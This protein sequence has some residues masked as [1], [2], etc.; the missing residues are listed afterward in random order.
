MREKVF[1]VLMHCG[2]YVDANLLEKGIYASPKPFIYSKEETIEGLI[3]QARE[4]QDFMG[5]WHLSEQYFVSLKQCQLVSF[6]LEI[7]EL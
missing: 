5:A 7:K 4:V 3:K 2:E 1:K 6:K